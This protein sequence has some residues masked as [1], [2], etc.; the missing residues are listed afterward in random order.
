MNVAESKGAGRRQC[1][2]AALVSCLLVPLVLS[3]CLAQHADVK[4]MGRSFD[5]K[6]TDLDQREK[7][8]DKRI[9]EAQQRIDQQS[10]EAERLVSEARARLRHDISQLREENIPKIQGRLDESDHRV[11]KLAEHVDNVSHQ[12]LKQ[13][14][15]T[16]KRLASVE[17]I[18]QAEL[19][20]LRS[21][22]REVRAVLKQVQESLR[23]DVGKVVVR[24]DALAPTIESLAKKIDV[25][26]EEQ[27][28]A[29]AASS[30]ETGKLVNQLD[31]QVNTL[32]D[33]VAQLGRSL[34]EFKKTLAAFG[35]RL[36][37]EDKKIAELSLT[38]AGQNEAIGKMVAAENTA[39][40]AHL[41]ELNKKVD[42]DMRAMTTH[43]AEVS[44]KVNADL[45]VTSAHL[46]RVS[47][48]VDADGK[49][50]AAHL[51]E[52]N[53]S[54]ASVAQALKTMSATILDR[55]EAQDSRLQETV[56]AV[57]RVT[58][59]INALN[60]V[61]GQ[62]RQGQTQ[63]FQPVE[64]GEKTSATPAESTLS[65]APGMPSNRHDSKSAQPMND[66]LARERYDRILAVFRQGDLEGARQGF[67][68]FLV[69]YPS[70][71]RAPNAQ[72]WL[73]ECFYG[74]QQYKEAIDA[75]QRVEFNY[76]D[77]E[78]VPAAMLKKG[79]AHLALKDRSQAKAILERVVQSYPQTPEA[80]KAAVQL[81]R[82]KDVQ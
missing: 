28:Q 22:Q 30:V 33:R 42:V 53:K 26:L 68:E 61:G 12:M 7:E 49:A 77:S 8:L 13:Q 81:N 71:A 76:P 65:S 9:E 62:P 59:E 43:L 79:Y 48:K 74:K 40:A 66:R 41:A 37:K 56:K 23:E 4:R 34:P 78:K 69:T 80:E 29:L 14:A 20:K 25:R 6:L 39:V 70:S 63:S 11:A 1:L 73:A 35:D 54:V 60:R 18:Q 32:N 67:S 38:V 36:V 46:E 45:K 21:D 75:F 16:E 15:G 24:L 50:T 64:S 72:Y 55:V 19:A 31:A 57:E 17:T 82:L 10:K 27:D 51:A 44:G 52:V 58:I 3:G 2:L 47:Q 5:R